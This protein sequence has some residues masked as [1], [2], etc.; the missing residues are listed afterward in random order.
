MIF[1][2]ITLFGMYIGRKLGWSLS[3]R[4]LY[5]SPLPI[6]LILCLGWG[7]GVALV[8]HLLITWQFPNIILKIIMGFGA[9]SYVSIPNFGLLS[10]ATIPDEALPRHTLISG[11]PLVAFIVS[12]VAFAFFL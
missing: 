4:V 10:Q 5:V 7:V 1:F 3:K 9:G 11:L 12:S 2:L 8:V 6:A